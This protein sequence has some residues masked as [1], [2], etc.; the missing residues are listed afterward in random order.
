MQKEGRRSN[1]TKFPNPTKGKEG[2]LTLPHSIPRNNL[3]NL[4]NLRDLIPSQPL[5]QCPSHIHGSP[6]PLPPFRPRL[7]NN[8][9]PNFLSPVPAW[10]SYDG[11]FF[12]L[13]KGEE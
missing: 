11:S 8:H 7:Q 10:D 1:R 4:H 5:L 2:Q 3:H 12:Y 13:W 6:A 9:R